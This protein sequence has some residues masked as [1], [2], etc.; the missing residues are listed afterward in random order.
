MTGYVKKALNQFQHKKRTK[1]QYAP[2]PC[3]CII[4]RA[5]KQYAT[6][7]SQAP[8]LDK[9]GKKFIQ[10]V[11]GKHLFLGRAV[12]PPLFCPISAIASQP[13]A[14]TKGTMK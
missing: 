13:A 11:C 7:A 5:K 1:Q 3:A 14:P 8:P 9:Y 2:Y 4:Y 6:Q 10:K 12:D